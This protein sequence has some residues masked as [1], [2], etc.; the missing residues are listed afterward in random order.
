MNWMLVFISISN[1][2]SFVHPTGG[3][4]I[5]SCSAGANYIIKWD[6]DYFSS[7][8]VDIDLWNMNSST[9]TSIATNINSSIGEYM[10]IF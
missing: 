1:L 9:F 3:Q 8:L 4:D 10:T 7:S 6:A 5:D 2:F